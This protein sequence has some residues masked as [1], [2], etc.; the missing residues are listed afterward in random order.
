[1]SPSAA[2]GG[3]FV[4]RAKGERITDR[5]ARQVVLLAAMEELSISWSRYGHGERGPEPHVHRKHVD[6]FYVLDGELAFTVG[7]GADRVRLPAGAF[8]A[9]PPNLVHSFVNEGTGD[10]KFLNFH[11]PDGGF[12]KFLRAGRD[13]GKA[14]FDS[15][16]PPP[17]GGLPASEA[18]VLGPSRGDPARPGSLSVVLEATLPELHMTEWAL[19]GPFE[20]DQPEAGAHADSLYVLSGELEVTIDGTAHRAGRETLALIPPGS[21]YALAHRGPG[22]VRLLRV[23]APGWE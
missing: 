11:T 9:A 22:T 1:M 13:G 5:R 4:N 8:L 12:A 2:A 16:H 6:S 17:D 18:I 19:E 15:V 3:R 23:Q 20:S 10:A 14:A 21:R 7:A